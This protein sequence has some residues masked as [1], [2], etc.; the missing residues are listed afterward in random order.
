MLNPP[1]FYW[2]AFGFFL[3][4]LRGCCE[5]SGTLSQIQPSLKR[6]ARISYFLPLCQ[7]SLQ[8]A[9]CKVAI[10]NTEA[11]LNILVLHGVEN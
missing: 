3:A 2:V 7:V 11:L 6:Q 5:L 10:K 9:R 8:Q 1:V 4:I